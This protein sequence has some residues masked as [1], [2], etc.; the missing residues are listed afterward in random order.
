[1]SVRINI[2]VGNERIEV[3][4]V[5]SGVDKHVINIGPDK[6]ETFEFDNVGDHH[7]SIRNAVE[8]SKEEERMA[9]E[10]AA[11]ETRA[12]AIAAEEAK[13]K[14]N[15]GELD[16]TQKNLNTSVADTSSSSSSSSAKSTPAS[17]ST[18]SKKS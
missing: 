15:P 12:T 9:I 1:M 10:A 5:V 2:A 6:N 3:R 16:V 4:H 17:S 11:E 13:A 8:P 14:P 18:T 7:F